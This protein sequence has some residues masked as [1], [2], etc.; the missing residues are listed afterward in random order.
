[1]NLTVNQKVLRDFNRATESEWVESNGLGGWTSSTV[2]GANRRRYH[3]L[4]VAAVPGFDEPLNMLSKLDETIVMGDKR[5]ELASNKYLNAVYPNGHLFMQQFKRSLFPSLTYKVG[6]I[7]LKKTFAAI[8]GENTVVIIYEVLEAPNSFTM[9]LCPLI[10]ARDVSELRNAADTMSPVADFKLGQLEYHASDQVPG[11]FVNVP[12]ASFKHKPDWYYQF[13]YLEGEPGQ[14]GNCEDLFT[15]G[16]FSLNLAPGEKLGIT[17]SLENVAFQNAFSLMEKE[18]ARRQV[19]TTS[20]NYDDEFMEQLVLAGDQ[21]IV[22]AGKN[23]RNILSGYHWSGETARDSLMAL[24]GLCLASGRYGD[25]KNILSYWAQKIEEDFLSRKQG[26]DATLA[27]DAPLWLFNA[28]YEYCKFTGDIDF[29]RKEIMHVMRKVIEWFRAG[30]HSGLRVDMDGLVTASVVKSGMSCLSYDD[31]ETRSGKLVEINAL[32]YNA[33]KAYSY[34]LD[35]TNK[36]QSSGTYRSMAGEV[37]KSFV[38]TFWNT[39][40]DYLYDSVEGEDK[41]ERFRVGQLL[42]IALPFPVLEGLKARKIY[43]HINGRLYTSAGLMSGFN[44]SQWDEDLPK[45]ALTWLLGLYIDATVRLDEERGE[46][47]AREVF[48]S[49]EPHLGEHCLGSVSDVFEY[50]EKVMPARKVASARA[51]GE[52]LRAGVGNEVFKKKKKVELVQEET[53]KGFFDRESDEEGMRFSNPFSRISAFRNSS[54]SRVKL[55]KS[56]SWS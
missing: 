2:T 4:L 56:Y 52:L 50:N 30:V 26:V 22:Y 20:L 38:K 49:F 3:G 7:T 25:A 11:L 9:E 27:I 18:R 31:K 8:S 53:P 54:S 41:D 32:W 17:V 42:A 14:E 19:L 37:K 43:K 24:P 5:I 35:L 10:G 48:R 45:V 46:Y 13:E 1:M 6:D 23:Q 29:V 39:S 34:L 36:N 28:A 55:F 47:H 15:P 40:E 16:S 33:L 51:I 21:F 12:G 44:A